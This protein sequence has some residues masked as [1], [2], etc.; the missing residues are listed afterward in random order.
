MEAFDILR[1]FT[2]RPD[3]PKGIGAGAR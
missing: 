1:S 2:L 3:A